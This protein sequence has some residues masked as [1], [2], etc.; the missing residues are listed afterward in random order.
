MLAGL[1][2]AQEPTVCIGSD[3]DELRTASEAA[4]ENIGLR[5]RIVR[6]QLDE[7]LKTDNQ[8]KARD[9][10]TEVETQLGEIQ[11]LGPDVSYVYRVLSRQHY[12][13]ADKDPSEYQAALD[14]IAKQEALGEIDFEMRTLKVRCLLR[15]GWDENDPKPERIVE[16]ARY[17]ADWFD[18]P[19]APVWSS[20]LAVLSTWLLDL[21]FRQELLGIVEARY[22]ETPDNMNLALTL[23]GAYYTLGRNESAWRVVHEAERRGLCDDV[24][25][26]RHV[27]VELLRKKCYEYGP[28]ASTYDGFNIDRL[29]ELVAAHPEDISLAYRLAIRL[30]AKGFTGEAIVRKIDEKLAEKL[31]EDRNF[32][33]SKIDQQRKTLETGIAEAYRDA[34]PLIK[35]AVAGNDRLDAAL[36]LLGDLQAKAGQTDAAAAT[37]REGLVRVPFFLELREKLA[38]VEAERKDWKAV[39]DQLAEVC[40]VAACD[41]TSWKR[42]VPGSLLPV[43]VAAREILMV[44]MVGKPEARKILVDTFTAA[45][46]ADDRNPNIRAYLGMIE[47]FAGNKAEASRWL[48]EAERCGLC[49][50][51]GFEH[52]LAVEV[53]SR[54]RW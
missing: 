20:T 21:S 32:D 15:L 22:A 47:Y 18:S 33:T 16:A 28:Q 40:K 54:E 48:R 35:T 37:L 26:G 24:T 53:F 39:A 41:P 19:T 45:A 49:G 5:M 25:G 31:K 50:E 12:R 6:R 29:R 46:K 14:C 27:I 51:V 7:F 52:P 17:V 13:K 30:R 34:I 36:L 1:L 3:I 42:D 9:L 23:A 11:K 4:P 10:L 2:A 43:P 38:E 44:D 8:R